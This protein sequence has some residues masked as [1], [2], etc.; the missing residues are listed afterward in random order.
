MAE[1]HDHCPSC[2][3]SGRRVSST[4]VDAM[5]IGGAQATY[6]G[7]AMRFCR[8]ASCGVVYFEPAG[9]LRFGAED[10]RVPVFQKSDDPKRLVCYCFRHTVRAVQDEADADGRSGITESITRRCRAGEDDCERTNPQGACCLGNVRRVAKQ[11]ESSGDDGDGECCDAPD[12]GEPDS[13]SPSSA[14]PGS[15]AARRARIGSTIGAMLAAL[16]ASACCWLPLVLVGGGAS[17]AG[18]AGVFESLRPYLLVVTAVMLGVG[19]FLTYRRRETCGPDGQ[20]GEPA[21]RG[22]S[23]LGIWLATAAA[24]VF[25]FVPDIIGSAAADRAPSAV[26]SVVGVRTYRISGMTCAGCTA[27]VRDAISGIDGVESVQVS[28]DAGSATVALRQSVD[29][30]E[31]IQ[32]IESLGY[33]GSRSSTQRDLGLVDSAD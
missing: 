17:A 18:V 21:G 33:E 19:F 22:L 5:L 15:G 9:T 7:E 30:G 3:Q 31:I 8:T 24:L 1:R 29:D 27:H 6:S 4:T 23:R 14:A 12:P 10:M 28:Y 26:S 20:C 11:T 13:S 16:L 25:V 2:E 32:A